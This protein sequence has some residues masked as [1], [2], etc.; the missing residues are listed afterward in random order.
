VLFVVQGDC[1]G[2]EALQN[3]TLDPAPATLGQC[4]LTVNSSVLA[5]ASPDGHLLLSDVYFR[6]ER[7]HE[8]QA[9]IVTMLTISAGV[10]SLN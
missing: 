6:L 5:T 3:V 9:G 7:T 8:Q 2:A 1:A 10:S 4:I